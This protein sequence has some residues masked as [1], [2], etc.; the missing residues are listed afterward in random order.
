MPKVALVIQMGYNKKTERKMAMYQI[1]K[2]NMEDME[3]ILEIYAYARSF[4]AHTGNPNQW[5]NTHPEVSQLEADIRV[6]NLYVAECASGIHGVFAFI[7]GEDPTYAY[8]EDGAWFWDSPYGT[9]HRIASDGT[10]G[11]FTAALSYCSRVISHLRIDTHHDN[12]VMQ[13]VIEKN[14]FKRCG[15]IYVS[16]GSPR[17][18]YE[19][20]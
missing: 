3:R 8:I 18:A 15:I 12:R 5:G 1:R 10:G 6:G 14:G 11:I 17:I 16:D 13:H 20:M 7:L 2:A 19:R 4:M 9:I